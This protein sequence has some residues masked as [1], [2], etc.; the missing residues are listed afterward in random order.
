MSSSE[1]ISKT[2]KECAE[3]KPLGEFYAHPRMR[4]G[5]FNRCKVC[6]RARAR[7]SMKRLREAEGYTA[8]KYGRSSQY[9][10]RVRLKSRYGITPEQADAMLEEQGGVCAICGTDEPGGRGFWNVDHDHGTGKV[11]GL[12]C[13]NCNRGIG[14]LGDDVNRLM[15]AAAYLLAHRD[16]LS[17]VSS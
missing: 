11:R 7:A 1:V 16:V 9:H 8:P 4:D 3:T 10:R 6:D 15:S 14:L 13:T 12:L 2:C 17:E 5:Y